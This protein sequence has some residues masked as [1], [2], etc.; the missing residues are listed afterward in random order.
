[1]RS[2]S[3]SSRAN[4]GR[5]PLPSRMRGVPGGP[6]GLA[7]YRRR[8]LSRPRCTMRAGRRGP[9][10]LSRH[11]LRPCRAALPSGTRSTQPARGGGFCFAG[12]RHSRNVTAG[13]AQR[14][15][16]RA[17][18]TRKGATERLRNAIRDL[19]GM[20]TGHPD[21]FRAFTWRFLTLTAPEAGRIG[22]VLPG[23]AFKIKGG[24]RIR[25]VISDSAR[26]VE[27]QLLTNKAQ[28]VFDD[29]DVRKLICL[30][31]VERSTSWR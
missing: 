14:G 9:A 7:S 25:Q 15:P 5:R 26:V 6:A 2:R 22:V 23:D 24:A 10:S 30:C 12:T 13:P 27:L 29:V 4:Q 18:Y 11:R 8:P 21:L 31:I 3:P 19:P 1:M 28:W 16:L 17:P 20:D